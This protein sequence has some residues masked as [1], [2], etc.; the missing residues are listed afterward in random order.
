MAGNSAT[1]LTP[2]QYNKLVKFTRQ[3]IL[4]SG[5]SPHRQDKLARP[6]LDFM[7]G[8]KQL[9]PF[10]NNS[11]S[12]NT[13][14]GSVL[15]FQEFSGRDRLTFQEDEFGDQMTFTGT[16]VHLGLE[17]VHQVLKDAG[18]KIM[19]HGSWRSA[20][21]IGEA[22]KLEIVNILA[23]EIL[24]TEDRYDQLLDSLL[25]LDGS[26]GVSFA[27][28]DAFLPV[29]NAAGSVGNILRATNPIYR[30][31]IATGLTSIAGGTL[32]SG[33]DNLFRDTNKIAKT[34]TVTK[35]FA[36]GLAMDALKAYAEN[37]H[38]NI[39]TN[40]SGIGKID[41]SISDDMV[42]FAG[43]KV[44]YDPTMDT[45]QD[46]LGSDWS[47]RIYGLNVGAWELAYDAHKEFT[48]PADEFDL[49]VSRFGWEG[50]YA[51]V[52]KQPNANFLATV[53]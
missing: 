16:Q 2:V 26:T 12:Y 51:L 14:V 48:R 1:Y 23:E 11:I 28:L 44:T 9:R 6:M 38:L 19:P 13:Q 31:Q 37:N 39:N 8:K 36:G 10:I 34:G 18:Y 35:L 43:L 21:K 25:H 42:N 53:A 32:R 33:L 22:Q 15:Q 27:G 7:L 40:L 49:R 30:H 47:K 4:N 3:Y 45:L 17:E 52:C 46:E 29:D 5:T 41:S 50:R 24:R 20:S